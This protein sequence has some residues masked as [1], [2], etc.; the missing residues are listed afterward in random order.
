MVARND[1]S[2]FRIYRA[3]HADRIFYCVGSTI[4]S[5][6]AQCS[7]TSTFWRIFRNEQDKSFEGV[8]SCVLAIMRNLTLSMILALL[9]N[10]DGDGGGDCEA[11]RL[12]PS[13]CDDFADMIC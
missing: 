3:Y 4:F 10:G 11:Q 12:V 6:I 13:G 1:E 9:G 2:E 8:R 7:T 5:K